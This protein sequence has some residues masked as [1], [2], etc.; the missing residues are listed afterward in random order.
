MTIVKSFRKTMEKVNFSSV[1]R[2]PH[3]SPMNLSPR[4][5]TFV[6]IHLTLDKYNKLIPKKNYR[7]PQPVSKNR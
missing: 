2:I 7:N 5:T 6:K 1:E 3:L 4:H